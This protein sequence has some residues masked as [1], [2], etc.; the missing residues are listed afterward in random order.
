M[1]KNILERKIQINFCTFRKGI[2]KKLLLLVVVVVVVMVRRERLRVE[3]K[4]RNNME[5]KNGNVSTMIYHYRL[6]N[7]LSLSSPLSCIYMCAT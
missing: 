6:H 7:F 1:M 4:I 5:R 3:K 2:E